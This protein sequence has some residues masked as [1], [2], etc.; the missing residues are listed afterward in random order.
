MLYKL[1]FRNMAK[2]V[3]DYTIYFLTLVLGVAIFYM[4]NSLESQD[5]LSS[6]SETAT[7]MMDILSSIMAVVSFF[8]AIVFY[9][10]II[11]ANR[12]LMRRRKEEFALY[13]M[14]GMGKLRI[15]LLLIYETMLI[16]I[17][18][19]VIGLLLGIILSQLL[20]LIIITL[21]EVDLRHYLFAFS[22]FAFSITLFCF[23]FM[24][25]CVMLFNTFTITRSSLTKLMRAKR[26][27]DGSHEKPWIWYVLVLLIGIL[28]LSYAYY[29][30]TVKSYT[31]QFPGLLG[32]MILLGIFATFLIFYAVAHGAIKCIQKW[33]GTYFHGLNSFTIRE[34]HSQL[35]STVGAMSIICILLFFTICIFS[36]AMSIHSFTL[37]QMETSLPCDLMITKT[38]QLPADGL[39]S[40]EQVQRSQIGILDELQQQG[41][42]IMEH[43]QDPLVINYYVIANEQDGIRIEDTMNEKSIQLIRELY[44]SIT[45]QS[46]DMFMEVSEYNR[47]AKLFQSE[48]ITLGSEEYAI[49]ADAEVW[50]QI[51]SIAMKE[52]SNIAVNGTILRPSSA[53]CTFGHVEM[54]ASNIN[55]GVIIV[56]DGILKRSQLQYQRIFTNYQGEDRFTKLS[57]EESFEQ[58][59]DD[60]HI[61]WVNNASGKSLPNEIALTTR[62]AIQENVWTLSLLVIFV[63][64]YLGIVF[65]LSC[66]VILALKQMAAFY[67]GRRR[68]QILF[69]MGIDR[70]DIC[71]SLFIQNMLFFGLPLGLAMIHSIFGLR[72]CSL[73]LSMS[74][75]KTQMDGIFPT[76][77]LVALI[78]GGY[79]MITYLCS[80]NVVREM[81]EV[82]W[83]RVYE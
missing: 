14:L 37:Q 55:E 3:R 8:V 23:S 38:M 59:L 43:F 71:R 70:Q 16:G 5:V 26:K 12:F 15:T 25:V 73:L 53:S 76:I 61:L 64:L 79:F 69:M 22:P 36:S 51:R 42:P 62:L 83:N 45:L 82:G 65:L 66:A 46:H 77:L 27:N 17:V 56:P 58:F 9:F 7:N 68:Y 33:K 35:H 39:Y 6:L 2:S 40:T 60:R 44:P 41:Y 19:L 10:L 29:Q 11:Y 28:L 54:N 4:F 75:V 18:S 74:G 50:I 48:P 63:G 20:S 1:A 80:R 67:D 32:W 47:L 21:F 30:V 52:G 34:L 81:E 78:Y 13:Q 49:V 57:E 24:Y 31:I 72:F